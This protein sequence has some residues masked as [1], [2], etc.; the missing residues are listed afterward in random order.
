MVP[1]G[2]TGR[3][4]SSFSP[5][6]A[7]TR[8]HRPE[9]RQ[10]VDAGARRI[11]A[12]PPARPHPPRR[13]R[14]RPVGSDI[15]QPHRLPA[16]GRRALRRDGRREHLALRARPTPTSSSRRR[17]AGVH[18][19]ILKPNG[20][21][22]RSASRAR[23]SAASASASRS[24]GRSTGAV[25]RRPRRAEL[26]PTRRATRR[27]RRRSA[28]PARRHR[29]VVAHRPSALESVDMA[30]AMVS[31]GVAASGRRRGA[32]QGAAANWCR[33]QRRRRQGAPAGR[34]AP[35]G[36]IVS[37]SPRPHAAPRRPEARHPRRHR[38]A[39]MVGGIA[40]AVILGLGGMAE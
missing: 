30:L 25:P 29:H 15:R 23:L 26:N 20:Y 37:S 32:P 1:P 8:H 34:T 33:S 2:S 9:R 17:G 35:G 40:A 10:Q 4:C 19:F 7:T 13:R 28:S 22:A 11:G 21:S 14:P 27:C 5:R 6:P 16:A 38:P 39:V 18:D 3:R 24:P 12:W 36:R 31:S